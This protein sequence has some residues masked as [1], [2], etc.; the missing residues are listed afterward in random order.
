VIPPI[1]KDL[2]KIKK[3]DVSV[4][5]FL[6]IMFSSVFGTIVYPVDPLDMTGPP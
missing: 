4:A 1:V 3:L 5:I 6:G 2:F